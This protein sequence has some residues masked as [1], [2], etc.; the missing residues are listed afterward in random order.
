MIN[1]YGKGGH[2]KVVGSVLHGNDHLR[3]YNDE[4]FELGY[5]LLQ[6]VIINLGKESLKR[7]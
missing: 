3:F 7:Y 5:G 4:D 2:A 6:L 1:I